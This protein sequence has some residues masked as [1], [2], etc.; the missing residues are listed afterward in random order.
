[1]HGPGKIYQN[2]QNTQ[3]GE[4]DSQGPMSRLA[5]TFSFPPATRPNS[6]QHK[7][8]PP[9]KRCELL[10]AQFDIADVKAIYG[11]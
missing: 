1:M 9:P 5:G 2:G 4:P 11:V 10:Y 6:L 3:Q 7:G 8:P